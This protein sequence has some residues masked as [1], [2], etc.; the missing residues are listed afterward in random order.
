MN[1]TTDIFLDILTEPLVI[2]KILVEICPSFYLLEPIKSDLP[3][4]QN[5]AH[6]KLFLFSMQLA[7]KWMGHNPKIL[8]CFLGVRFSGTIDQENL[9]QRLFCDIDLKINLSQ[10]LP[11]SITRK[12]DSVAQ[13]TVAVRVSCTSPSNATAPNDSLL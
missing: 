1:L 9:V 2:K 12:T 5:L 7:L 8:L 3:K 4:L 6:N 13:I 10:L 11:L